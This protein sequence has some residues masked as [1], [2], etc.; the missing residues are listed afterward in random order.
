MERMK[1]KPTIADTEE[2]HSGAY[3]QFKRTHTSTR[4]TR[5]SGHVMSIFHRFCSFDI[6]WFDVIYFIVIAILSLSFSL[7]R[8]SVTESIATRTA[9]TTNQMGRRNEEE[10]DLACK[11]YEICMRQWF[12]CHR[13]FSFSLKWF[14]SCLYFPFKFLF[15]NREWWVLQMVK[16]M[17]CIC[18]SLIRCVWIFIYFYLFFK[19]IWY[20]LFF[21]Y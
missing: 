17:I 15:V 16:H 8:T 7:S 18:F 3:G 21:F 14:S 20:F 6:I 9:L 19:D 4:D 10:R 5:L 2:L 12:A 1:E 11:R 13:F